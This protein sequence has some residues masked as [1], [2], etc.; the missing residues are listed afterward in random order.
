MYSPLLGCIILHSR[1]L[2]GGRH[3][4]SPLVIRVARGSDVMERHEL[5]LVELC[6][7][8][9]DAAT[10]ECISSIYKDENIDMMVGG[11][12]EMRPECDDEAECMLDSMWDVW[13][14]GLPSSGA[15]E[16]EE[17]IE[18]EPKVTQPMRRVIRPRPG[19]WVNGWR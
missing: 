8:G 3:E 18:E 14:D 5:A 9:D 7:I 10:A 11:S 12:E 2:V 6:I 16:E 17:A 19:G 4:D 13:S 1:S 15:N